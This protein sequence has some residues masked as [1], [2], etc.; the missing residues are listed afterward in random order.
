MNVLDFEVNLEQSENIELDGVVNG[1]LKTIN[2]IYPFEKEVVA[3]VILH[4][5]WKLKSKF[6]LT[7]NVPD[8]DIQMKYIMND[9]KKLE[10]EIKRAKQ[11]I[12]TLPI[13]ILSRENIEEYIS[14]A[15]LTKFID[16]DFLPIDNSVVNNS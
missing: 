1:E 8:R 14:K 11:T 5:N 12:N 6:K 13:E 7:I 9:Q 15:G 3:M 10:D 16:L 2:K 4:N